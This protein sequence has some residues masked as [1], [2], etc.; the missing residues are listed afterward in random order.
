VSAGGTSTLFIQISTGTTAASSTYTGDGTSGIYLWGAQ[1]EQSSTV[2]EYIPTTSTIN[3]AP[4]FDHAPTTGESLGLLVEEQRTNLLL[5]S[6]VFGTTWSVAGTASITADQ[7]AA[8]NGTTTADRITVT[9]SGPNRVL[10]AGVSATSTTYTFS[11]YTKS[12]DINGICIRAFFSGGTS[13]DTYSNFVFGS[14]TFS[15]TGGSGTFAFQELQ[16]GWFRLSVTIASGN[17]TAWEFRIGGLIA[18]AQTGTKAFLWGAQLEAGAFPTSYI[19]TTTATVTRS[20]DVASI[21]GSNFSG[22]F[23][24]N[25][26]TMYG[27]GFVQ[28][29][30]SASFSR[31]FAAVGSNAG[32]DE[33]SMYTRVN[34]DPATNG[35]IYGAVTVSSVLTGDVQPPNGSTAGNYV[36]AFAYRNNDFALSN[37]GTAP[38]TDT[39][40]SLPACERLLLYGSARFQSMPVGYIK[41]FTY[42]PRRLSDSTLQEITR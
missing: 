20:A 10:Q 33:I 41:R 5:Q 28:P 13:I 37:N 7:A 16:N 40:G 25:E 24:G 21:S 8:P 34:V 27:A 14:K 15:D 9:S 42:W 17:N 23:N 19:P 39:S 3:S 35:R 18:T 38:S 6:E 32:T 22:W 36:S 30:G 2:G 11:V 29:T 1:L 31:L 4:R 12:D 26:G